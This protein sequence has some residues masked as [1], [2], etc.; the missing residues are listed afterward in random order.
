MSSAPY[1][2][3]AN[4]AI[5][6]SQEQQGNARCHPFLLT[7]SIMAFPLP[8][9]LAYST[10]PESSH[11]PQRLKV[12]VQQAVGKVFEAL[13]ASRQRNPDCEVTRFIRRH[14]GELTDEGESEGR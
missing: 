14:G 9:S 8:R 2:S 11:S 3:A 10:G 6:S 13:L 12:P 4:P 5:L 1:R 7:R